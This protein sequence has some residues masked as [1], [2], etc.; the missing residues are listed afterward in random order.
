MFYALPPA[1][2]PIAVSGGRMSPDELARSWSPFAVRWHGSGTS[3]LAAAVVAAIARKPVKEPEVLLPAYSCPDVV[4]AVLFA[5][6]KPILIDISRDRPWLDLD[7][8]ERRVGSDTVAIIAVNFLGIPERIEQLRSLAATVDAVLIEDRAQSFPPTRDDVSALGGDL[9]VLSFGRGKPVSLLGGGAVLARS[10]ELFELLPAAVAES[11]AFGLA[12]FRMCTAAYNALRRPRLYWMLD[13]VPFVGLGATVFKALGKLEPPPASID[14]LGAN[15]ER[16]R[17]CGDT[18][19]TLRAALPDLLRGRAI[20]LPAACSLRA[21]GRLLRYPILLDCE[22]C[23]RAHAAMRRAGL[24]S[25]RLYQRTLPA[26]GGI[27]DDIARQGGFPN[28]ERFAESL[29]TLPTHNEVRARDIDRMIA[30]LRSELESTTPG[31]RGA[32][33]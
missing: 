14:Y 28:A 12:R 9:V 29:L 15:I 6:A 23:S 16:Y 4:S 21:G 1:G 5:G 31:A 22:V 7:V 20:D 18:A 2:N 26:I 19:P 32:R 8:A 13:V 25:S 27:P 17:A 11:P 30:I 3:A 33:Y 10:T 24:G